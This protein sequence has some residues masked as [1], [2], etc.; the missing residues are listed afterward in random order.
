MSKKN[1]STSKGTTTKHT[2]I[3]QEL[4]NASQCTSYSKW[5][6]V[7]WENTGIL[8]NQLSE[9]GLQ[10]NNHHNASQELNMCIEPLGWQIVKRIKTKPNESWAWFIQ[11]IDDK[12]AAQLAFNLSGEVML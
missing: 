4:I 1:G 7:I 10:S 2:D 12:P 9:H 3:L 5:L 11:P 6:R 8:T